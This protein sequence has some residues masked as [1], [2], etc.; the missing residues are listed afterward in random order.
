MNPNLLVIPSA[1]YEVP[2][3]NQDAETHSDTAQ[4]DTPGTTKTEDAQATPSAASVNNSSSEPST[5]NAIRK[6]SKTHRHNAEAS[7]ENDTESSINTTKKE[8][9]LAGHTGAEKSANDDDEFRRD[10]FATPVTATRVDN[11]FKDVL[12]GSDKTIGRGTLGRG[13][14]KGIRKALFAVDV[15]AEEDE[16]EV[17]T[18]VEHVDVVKGDK[19]EIDKSSSPKQTSGQPMTNGTSIESTKPNQDSDPKQNKAQQDDS[20]PTQQTT[21]DEEKDEPITTA[22]G[23]EFNV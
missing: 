5:I 13:R 22:D 19:L 18:H 11:G 7:A 9:K 6:Q 4:Q 12:G 10:R 16:D 17:D 3:V 2:D 21:A 23:I 14:G 1:A 8:L 20:P 15:P